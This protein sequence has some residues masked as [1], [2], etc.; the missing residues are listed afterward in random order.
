MKTGDHNFNRDIGRTRMKN[1]KN[2]FIGAAIVLLIFSLTLV[3]MFIIVYRI[4][5]IN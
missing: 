1:P 4:F 3:L 5:E 2:P